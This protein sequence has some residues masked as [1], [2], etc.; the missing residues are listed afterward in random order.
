M[1]PGSTCQGIE[2]RDSGDAG[3]NTTSAAQRVCEQ[4]LQACRRGRG[5]VRQDAG[6]P[7]PGGRRLTAHCSRRTRLWRRNGCSYSNAHVT[8]LLIGYRCRVTRSSTHSE[9]NASQL[10]EHVNMAFET[11]AKSSDLR[12]VE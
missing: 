10:I 3:H 11:P 7:G 2:R 6:R 5:S 1:L 12:P 9:S 8:T 4:P